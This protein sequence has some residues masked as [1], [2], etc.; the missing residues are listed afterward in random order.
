MDSL[1]S[2]L[3]ELKA[4]GALK[5]VFRTDQLYA[6]SY[7]SDA[8]GQILIE[9]PS[10]YSIDAMRWNKRKL[11]GK[12]L[13]TKKGVHKREGI[14]LAYGKIKPEIHGAPGIEDLVP[15]ILEMMR[16][17]VPASVDGK[18]LVRKNASP[19]DVRVLNVA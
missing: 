5:N 17:P 19:L 11:I 13:L 2:G 6:G 8:P 15:T 9:G 4:S 1:E 14:L 10:G 3:N 7:L 12:P 16:L 18:P